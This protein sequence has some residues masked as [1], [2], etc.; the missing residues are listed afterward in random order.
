MAFYLR[1][2]FKVGPLR[3][4]LSK[5]G[6]GL[7][8]GVTG[9]RIGLS[10]RGAYVHG[11]RH[12]IYYRKY[13]KKG[14]GN[15]TGSRPVSKSP[16]APAIKAY[17]PNEAEVLKHWQRS[18]TH[19]TLIDT[20]ATFSNSLTT[21]HAPYKAPDD[22]L[23]DPTFYKGPSKLILV[24]ST[25]AFFSTLYFSTVTMAVPFFLIG[26]AAFTYRMMNDRAYKQAEKALTDITI[27]TEQTQGFPDSA[28]AMINRLPKRWKS[29]VSIKLQIILSELAMRHEGMDM[30]ALFQSLDSRLTVSPEIVAHIRGSIFSM[31]L[32]EMLGDHELDEKEVQSI[33][34]ILS[35]VE[36]DQNTIVRETCR[37]N[38]YQ[39]LREASNE[40]LTPINVDIPLVRGEIAYFE[41]TSVRLLN[42]RVQNRYQHNKVQHVELGYEIE[43]EGRLV[44]TDR[45]ILLIDSGSRELRINQILD[46]T[47]DPDGGVIELTMSGRQTPII[48]S[49]PDVMILAAKIQKVLDQAIQ[50]TS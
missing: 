20:N 16:S 35:N 40:D 23:P 29:W 50:A 11:G 8:T 41:A 7:S 6:L 30:N 33:H 12:G 1:K 43:L 32:D 34:R 15:P 31:I 45:R 14:K 46:I 26:F 17:I 36:L 21:H 47:V 25:L 13:L 9:A 4:N 5:S 44:L 22:Y 28:I 27:R 39:T 18:G 10:P 24:L 19:Y 3:L 42:E 49:S 37:I 38:H 48:L 2:A